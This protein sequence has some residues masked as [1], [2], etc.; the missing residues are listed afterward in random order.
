VAR[1]ELVMEPRVR[2]LFRIPFRSPMGDEEADR[3]RGA[4]DM[5]LSLQSKHPALAPPLGVAPLGPGS[6][7]FLVRGEEDGEWA[8]E[9]RTW[10]DPSPS[11]AREWE[12]IARLAA[13][14]LDPSVPFPSPRDDAGEVGER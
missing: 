6:G 14:R 10:E 5:A 8:L 4:L 13:R 2:V 12:L 1:D 3:L 9:C 11:L 7:L